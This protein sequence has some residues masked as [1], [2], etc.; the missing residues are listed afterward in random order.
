MGDGGA[1]YFPTYYIARSDH[2]YRTT[3]MQDFHIKGE[4]FI[5]NPWGSKREVG[6]QFVSISLD[7]EGYS[8]EVG[9]ISNYALGKKIQS[10]PNVHV[11]PLAMWN[12]TVNV[13]VINTSL[14]KHILYTRNQIVVLI[15]TIL[16][17]IMAH[18]ILW[19]MTVQK[20]STNLAQS[21]RK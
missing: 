6:H 2:Q 5:E 19:Y 21:F 12:N 18:L 20:N 3:S 7:N 16:F 1:V 10:R 9:K 13:L 17:N 4:E 8:K 15:W 14:L 11:K